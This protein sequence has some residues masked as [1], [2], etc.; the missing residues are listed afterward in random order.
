MK[1]I[2]SFA[3]TRGCGWAKAALLLVLCLAGN[4]LC[5]QNLVLRVQASKGI[6]EVPMLT[7][8]YS[9][10]SIIEMRPSSRDNSMFRY[11]LL[12]QRPVYAEISH[13]DMSGPLGLF[14]ESGVM[15]VTLNVDNPQSS[16]VVG[17]LTNT[18][19]RYALETCNETADPL[20]VQLCLENKVRMNAHKAWAPLLMYKHLLMSPLALQQVLYKMLGEDAT[21][22]YHYGLLGRRIRN[23]EMT[24]EGCRMPNFGYHDTLD[25]ALD[26]FSLIQGNV[27][28]VLC[29]GATWCQQCRQVA[30]EA[31]EIAQPYQDRKHPILVHSI[32]IDREEAVWD[33]PLATSLAIEYLPSIFVVDSVGVIVCRDVRVWELNHVFD[34]L[35]VAN[36]DSR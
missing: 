32:D 24:T 10:D 3:V 9:V 29:F 15:T 20:Q 8:Y 17:S 35:F 1:R 12:V 16:L 25:T 23:K 13:P 21:S 27:Y 34:S 5:S 14:L 22:A 33:S 31:D 30:S 6:K 11:S 19:Y 28:H 7:V 26:F 36:P 2:L 4:V 18:E